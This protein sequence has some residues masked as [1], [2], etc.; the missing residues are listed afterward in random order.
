MHSVELI[1]GPPQCGKSVAAESRTLELSGRIGKRLYVA[2]LPALPQFAERIAQHRLRRG[3]LWRMVEIRRDL[4]E[5]REAIDSLGRCQR[6]VLLDGISAWIGRQIDRQM[7]LHRRPRCPDSIAAALL[8]AIAEMQSH[9]EHLIVVGTVVEHDP[10]NDSWTSVAVTANEL[11][12]KGI[13][14]FADSVT[15][16][17]SKDL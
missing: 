15:L 12:L 4:A 8:R 17:P 16:L 9:C 11:V 2:T 10:S 5:A 13:A 3:D 14:Q 6:H 7:V 1:A